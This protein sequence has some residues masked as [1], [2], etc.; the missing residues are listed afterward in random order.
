MVSQSHGRLVNYC[1]CCLHFSICSKP[2]R[3]TSGY[4]LQPL[5]GVS[6]H[7]LEGSITTI[8]ISSPSTW[9]MARGTCRARRAELQMG[10]PPWSE[11]SILVKA[12]V[13][14]PP[15]VCSQQGREWWRA[16]LDRLV[17]VAGKCWLRASLCSSRATGMLCPLFHRSTLRQELLFRWMPLKNEWDQKY[18]GCCY[19]ISSACKAFWEVQTFSASGQTLNS[20][21]TRLD[22]SSH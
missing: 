5:D 15:T 1:A 4:F 8:V 11:A 6:Q 9:H 21:H 10:A 16:S 7:S 22:P 20:H 18:F 17:L 14:V 2:L 3:E 13:P 12:S 19:F